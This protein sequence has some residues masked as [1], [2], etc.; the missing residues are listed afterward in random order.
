MR[1][2]ELLEQK[3]ILEQKLEAGMP[4]I[5]GHKK[6][7]KELYEVLNTPI[8]MDI[9]KNHQTHYRLLQRDAK[10]TIR[11]IERY[12]APIRKKLDKIN[13]YLIDKNHGK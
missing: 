4:F 2:E 12:E 6:T 13:T 5:Y 7:L 3:K 11:L 8:P 10:R 9:P 1:K